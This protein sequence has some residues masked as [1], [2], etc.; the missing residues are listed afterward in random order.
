[1]VSE[2]FRFKQF[3]IAHDRCAMKV[4]TDGVLLGAWAGHEQPTNILDIGTGS[5][6][7]ALMLA[8]RFPLAQITSLEIDLQACQQAKENFKQSS[9]A[10]RIEA[11]CTDFK[12]FK[13][14]GRFDLIVSNPPFHSEDTVPPSADRALARSASSF[15][16]DL[17]FKKCKQWLVPHGRLQ[18][19][20]PAQSLTR[21]TV[22]AKKN[23]F[24]LIESVR[25]QGQAHR[26]AKRVLCTFEKNHKNL[27][28]ST[29]IL[30]AQRHQPTED[31]R[32]LCQ[33]FYLHF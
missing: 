24:Y 17:F 16:L 5:G 32:K 7:V 4:G 12:N 20:L 15:H 19:V 1:M 14:S 13:P 23:A 29:L 10:E 22:E 21:W 11:L 6:L 31:Y 28:E 25:V 30:E 27:V 18:L 9:W 8:Q 3:S 2:P 26:P 33:E